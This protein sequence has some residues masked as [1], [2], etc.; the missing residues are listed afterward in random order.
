MKMKVKRN[1]PIITRKEAAKMLSISLTTLK[2]WTDLGFLK[3]YKL[4]GRIYYK[5]N[6]ILESLTPV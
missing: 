1:N 2:S 4:G 3:S 5:E 6:E